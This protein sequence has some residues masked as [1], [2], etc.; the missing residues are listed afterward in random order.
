MKG[1]KRFCLD[2][3][4]NEEKAGKSV[5]KE[6]IDRINISQRHVMSFLTKRGRY[7]APA[8]GDPSVIKKRSSQRMGTV[9][10]THTIKPTA[11]ANT[12]SPWRWI[13]NCSFIKLIFLFYLGHDVLVYFWLDICISPYAMLVQKRIKEDRRWHADVKVNIRVPIAHKMCLLTCMT[14]YQGR[15][16]NHQALWSWKQKRTNSFWET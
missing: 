11:F 3:K 8:L 7:M 1:G 12:F 10:E 5:S 16:G 9:E 6:E 4:A 2:S 14:D 13:S 15:K